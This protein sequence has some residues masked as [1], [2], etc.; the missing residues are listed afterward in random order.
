MVHALMMVA[1]LVHKGSVIIH[2]P[3]RRNLESFVFNLLGTKKIPSEINRTLDIERL[4]GKKQYRKELRGAPDVKRDSRVNQGNERVKTF[5][6][7][8][9]GASRRM[10]DWVSI[11]TQ[12][13]MEGNTEQ[14]GSNLGLI[15]GCK[16]R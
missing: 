11:G 12:S 4:T 2:T 5:V 9:A 14:I 13:E 15:Q 16:I 8:L 10:N 1:R 6:L 3:C 7:L